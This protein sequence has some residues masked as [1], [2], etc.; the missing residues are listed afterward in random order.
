MARR[1]RDDVAVVV[2]SSQL[3]GAAQLAQDRCGSHRG[4]APASTLAS[5]DCTAATVPARAHG[6]GALLEEYFL[7]NG[8]GRRTLVRFPIHATTQMC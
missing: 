8:V 7:D 1:G 3:V 5:R 6:V 2:G 4:K